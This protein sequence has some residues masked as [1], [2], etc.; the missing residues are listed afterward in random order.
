MGLVVQRR[1]WSWIRAKRGL[2]Q[3]W[4][5]APYFK[6][7][8]TYVFFF[9]PSTADFEILNKGRTKN[10]DGGPLANPRAV[11]SAEK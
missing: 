7:F 5:P 11:S 9:S 10:L 6:Y 1:W 2:P 3:F 8:S 4:A